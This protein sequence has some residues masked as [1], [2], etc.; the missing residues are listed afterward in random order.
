MSLH[1]TGCLICGKPL[2]YFE[3]AVTL[4]CEICGRE[5]ESAACCEDRHFVCDKCHAQ[6]GYESITSHALKTAHTNPVLIAEEMMR[7]AFI[8]MHGP[9]HHYLIIAALLAAYKN[10]GGKIDLDKALPVARQR[11]EKV[12]G[13]ICGLWGACGAGI[14]AGIFISIITGATP[15]SAEEWKL[16]NQMT[17]ASL[18]AISNHGG[19][20]CCKRD[21]Y[22]SILTA[23][24]FVKDKLGHDMDKP[25]SIRCIFFNNNPSC[26]KRGCLF[27]PK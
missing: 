20:R 8:N 17:S 24:G 7:H 1:K 15:L 19:P 23:V 25:E 3:P 22:L 2:E 5:L 26:K 9:E 10:S 6:A 14:G 21:T 11:A 13:G 18:E 12:P 4:K 16:A 27:Y